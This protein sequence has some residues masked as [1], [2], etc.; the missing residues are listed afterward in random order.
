MQ[1]FKASDIVV[2]LTVEKGPLT[3]YQFEGQ[4]HLLMGVIDA[5][6]VQA[7]VLSK[8]Q[9]KHCRLEDVKMRTSAMQPEPQQDAWRRP[10]QSRPYEG[11]RY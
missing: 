9:L 5:P 2:P 4:F 10:Y 7:K 3:V 1:S 6:E 11:R 8:H